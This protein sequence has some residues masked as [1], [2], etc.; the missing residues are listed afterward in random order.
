MSASGMKTEIGKYRED[1][2]KKT[3]LMVEKFKNMIFGRS[4]IHIFR[5]AISRTAVAI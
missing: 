5:A 2:W 4:S 1:K 3:K